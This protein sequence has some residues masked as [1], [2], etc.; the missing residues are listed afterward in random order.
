MA[1]STS[2][3]PSTFDP[4]ALLAIQRRNVEA[5]TQAGQIVAEGM[6]TYAGRQVGMMQEAMRDLWGEIQTRGQ[7]PTAADPSDQLARLRASFDKVL[8]QIQEL[9]QVLLTAQSEA[10]AVLNDC[11]AA[12]VQALGGLAPDF[13]GMQRTATETMQNATRQVSAAIEEMRKRM[14]ALQEET[15]QVMGTAQESTAAGATTASETKR[16][17]ST[18]S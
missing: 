8:A 2:K 3:T 12:N 14:T 1:E 9:S 10:M 16:K 4:E 6:R 15:R 13:A 17:G 18:R 7:A 11:A 5:F